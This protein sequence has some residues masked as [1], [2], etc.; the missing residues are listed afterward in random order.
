MGADKIFWLP[1]YLVREDPNLEILTPE[2]LIKTLDNKNVA[3][4]AE[5]NDE[6]GAK[7]RQLRAD[8]WLIVLMT[9][10]PADTWLRGVFV[11]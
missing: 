10:G 6:F 3:E 1:T 11:V 2:F 5:T 7:I 8:G 9:A 4:V